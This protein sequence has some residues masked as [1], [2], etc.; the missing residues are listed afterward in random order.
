[1]AVIYYS[2]HGTEIDGINYLIPIDA[3]LDD[4]FDAPLQAIPLPTVM[5]QLDGSRRLR[6]V[7]LDA[8]RDNPSHQR[9]AQLADRK[10][11]PT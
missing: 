2:G 11:G 5:R 8:C 9:L 3:K 4:H 1:M 7:I 6:V 10:S